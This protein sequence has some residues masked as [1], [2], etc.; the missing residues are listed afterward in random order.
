MLLDKDK[1]NITA[2]TIVFMQFYYI[3]ISLDN[4]T[5]KENH[6]PMCS[7]LFCTGNR[8]KKLRNFAFFR[9]L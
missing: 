4:D 2:S 7:F 9:E 5:H 8:T 6:N 3:I 1:V